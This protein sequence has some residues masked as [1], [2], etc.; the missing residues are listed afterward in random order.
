MDE[1]YPSFPAVDLYAY[2]LRY[3]DCPIAILQ[4]AH[5]AVGEMRLRQATQQVVGECHDVL[6]SP[7]RIQACVI[8]DLAYDL[9]DGVEFI[10]IEHYLQ[11]PA[12]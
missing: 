7:D 10:P 11:K 5:D 6:R 9:C 8:A 12:A 2:Y 4:N 1:R 3:V